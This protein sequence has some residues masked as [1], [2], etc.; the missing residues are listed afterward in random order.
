MLQPLPYQQRGDSMTLILQKGLRVIGEDGIEILDE[1]EK[2][3]AIESEKCFFLMDE[4]KALEKVVF[5]QADNDK[6]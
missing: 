1:K 2:M 5:P 3:K 6:E 4:I